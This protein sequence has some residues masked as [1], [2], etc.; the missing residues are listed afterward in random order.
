MQ[1]APYTGTPAH[2]GTMPSED[3]FEAKLMLAEPLQVVS[4]RLEELTW[5]Q[6]VVL[7]LKLFR[8]L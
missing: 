3:G 4:H 6:P 1:T 8:S 2:F 7:V 5:E